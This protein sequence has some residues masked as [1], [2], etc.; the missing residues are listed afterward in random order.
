[1][2]DIIYEIEERISE[3]KSRLEILYLSKEHYIDIRGRIDELENVLKF[4]PPI[5][6]N[7]I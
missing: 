5:N 7:Q 2:G 3:L 6:N 1:M 4:L